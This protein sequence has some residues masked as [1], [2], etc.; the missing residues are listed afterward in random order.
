[1][2]IDYTKRPGAGGAPGAG[3]GPAQR[4]TGG[5]ARWPGASR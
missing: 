1:M 3:G 4:A 2:Q 5:P